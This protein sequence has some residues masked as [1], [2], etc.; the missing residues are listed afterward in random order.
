VTGKPKPGKSGPRRL[1]AGGTVVFLQQALPVNRPFIGC[2]HPRPAFDRDAAAAA[3][4]MLERIVYVS[5]AASGVDDR[6][7]YRIIRRAHAKN[8]AEGLSGALIFLDRWFAQLIEGP[9]PA[10]GRAFARIAA[11]P[12]HGPPGLRIRTAALARLFPGQAMALRLRGCLP[13]PLLAGFDYRPGFPVEAFPVDVLT[14]FMVRA[15]RRHGLAGLD[16]RWALS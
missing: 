1:S 15:C 3:E 10:V 12:R 13:E 2:R 7:V 14:E 16:K 8:G 5:R 6:E 9:P 11:D 4:A